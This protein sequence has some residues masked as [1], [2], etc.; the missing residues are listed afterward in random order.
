M[1]N[2][3]ERKKC[4]RCKVNLTLDKFTKKRD[5]TYQK[6]CIECCAK[7][8]KYKNA[9]KC[10]HNKRKERCDECGGSELCKHNKIKSQC[11]D[12]DG[13]SICEHNIRRHRCKE[14]SDSIQITITTILENAKT[15]DRNYNRYDSDHFIDRCFV[16][17]LLEKYSHCY[18]QD[19]KVKLQYIKYQNDLATIE[20]LDNSIGHIKPNCVI[21]CMRCNK[22]KK[23]NHN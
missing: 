5:D 7:A 14:C 2:N 18:Y 10:T 3:E 9:T 4:T 15:K 1:N 16:E 19:C 13:T 23:S 20:R 6:Q 12:C 21:C 22:L 17:N 11:I 8:T